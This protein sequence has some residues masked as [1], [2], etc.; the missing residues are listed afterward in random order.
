MKKILEYVPD[1][2]VV[3]LVL[4]TCLALRPGVKFRVG[5]RTR[6]HSALFL[7]IFLT[8]WVSTGE[9]KVPFLKGDRRMFENGLSPVTLV[10]HCPI[11]FTSFLE[12]APR[13]DVESAAE[14]MF[15]QAIAKDGRLE[16]EYDAGTGSVEILLTLTDHG[17]ADTVSFEP[18]T[19][20]K[21]FITPTREEIEENDPVED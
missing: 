2:D 10:R 21:Y 1:G 13:G 8:P 3:A 18:R 4:S 19:A 11:D 12:E 9:E 7:E 6:K 14:D 15:A 17:Y 16:A 5:A 20:K